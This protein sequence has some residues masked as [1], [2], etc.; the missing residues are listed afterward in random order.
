MQEKNVFS[1][2][3]KFQGEFQSFENKMNT[4]VTIAQGFLATFFLLLIK[5]QK[6]FPLNIQ[7]N[8]CQCLLPP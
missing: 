6:N 7:Q 4:T 8:S 3:K 2:K 5:Q 1:F